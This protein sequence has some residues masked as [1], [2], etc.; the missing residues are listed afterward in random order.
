MAKT[1]PLPGSRW[2]EVYRRRSAQRGISPLRR[3]GTGTGW[4]VTSA[5]ARAARAGPSAARRRPAPSAG[6]PPHPPAGLPQRGHGA[7]PLRLEERRLPARQPGEPAEVV[8]P[9][10]LLPAVG[11]VLAPVAA[12]RDEPGQ[13][14]R[15]R[16][17][18]P[19]Q[20]LGQEALDVHAV[21]LQGHRLQLPLERPRRRVRLPRPPEGGHR[22]PEPPLVGATGPEEPRGGDGVAAVEARLAQ[23]RVQPQRVERHLHVVAR[24]RLRG[25]LRVDDVEL[26]LGRGRRVRLAQ[27]RQ[28][29]GEA[30]QPDHIRAQGGQGQAVALGQPPQGRPAPG[31]GGELALDHHLPWRRAPQLRQEVGG[32]EAPA[33][34]PLTR[35]PAAPAVPAPPPRGPRSARGRGRRPRAG[36]GSAAPPRP[37]RPRSAAA[38]PAAPGARPAAAIPSRAATARGHRR[39]PSSR[40]QSCWNARA[41]TCLSSRG[42]E[43]P[44]DRRDAAPPRPR[45]GHLRMQ[46]ETAPFRGQR[47]PASSILC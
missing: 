15:A 9:L 46:A 21:H 18:D 4:P 28:P 22:L 27:Q 43:R 36:R 24:R 17:Q 44:A 25:Q 26:E 41:T 11:Q 2:R 10:R 3:S 7:D 45:F 47:K 19:R 13:V 16:R 14:P 42:P 31:R 34:R 12:G 35:R 23:Q 40:S 20:A 29:G 5:S 1:R 33:G 8:A 6:T 38:G 32:T 30:A 37:G 39:T